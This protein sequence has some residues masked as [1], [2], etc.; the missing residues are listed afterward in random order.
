MPALGHAVLDASERSGNGSLGAIGHAPYATAHA[1]SERRAL[2]Q[3][4]VLLVHG[5]LFLG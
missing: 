5:Y 2:N 1:L 4:E 3:D